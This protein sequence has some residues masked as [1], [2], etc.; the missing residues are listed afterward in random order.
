MFIL[1]CIGYLFEQRHPLEEN[2]DLKTIK[3]M[4]TQFDSCDGESN[5]L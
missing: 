5:E 1:F 4:E 2:N 3:M